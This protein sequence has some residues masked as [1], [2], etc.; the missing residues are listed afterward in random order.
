LILEN[1][2]EEAFAHFQAAGRINPGDPMSHSNLGTYY[3]NHGRMLEAAEQ[4]EAA[5]NLTSDPGL[6]AQTYANLGTVYLGLGELDRA[7]ESF[8]NS[9]H[10]NPAPFNAWLG[11]GKLA[12]KAGRTQ[13]AIDNFSRSLKAQPT[14]DAF[15]HLGRCLAQTG[16]TN[17]ALA[18]YN[19]ALN[20]S[21]DLAEAQKAAE[22]LRKSGQ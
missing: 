4:Y 3:Q 16:R 15:L 7:R 2:E 18:A 14:A 6:L 22:A 8:H 20:I 1:R 9:L 19:Q 10:H 21:P 13:E 17:E 11:L 12:E 5:V